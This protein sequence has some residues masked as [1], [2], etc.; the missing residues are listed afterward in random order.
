MKNLIISFFAVLLLLPATAAPHRLKI[1]T[2]S[3]LFGPIDQWTYET[4]AKAKAAGIDAVE[5]SANALFLDKRYTDDA[6]IEARCREVKADLEKA[7]IAVWSIHMPFGEKIDLS[8]TDES[9]RQHTVALHRRL[10]RFCEILAPHIILFHPSWYLGLGERPQRIDCLVRSVNELLPDVRKVGAIMVVENLL[11][12]ELVK[13]QIHERPLGRTVEEMTYILSRLPRRVY[14]AVDTNHID[15]PEQLIQALGRRVKTVHISDGDGRNECHVL[16]WQPSGDN[17]WI[18]VLKALYERAHYKGVFMYEVKR[19]EFS[20]LKACYD[21]MY[22]D[23]CAS[24]K[25]N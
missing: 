3:G 18:A 9:V 23:Y 21:K 11:G 10:L 2:S 7:G 15:N 17:D 19:A 16:P 8:Q 6:Q 25:N 5:I 22:D 4:F 20:D 24:F 1:G 12:Y 14:A 13:D